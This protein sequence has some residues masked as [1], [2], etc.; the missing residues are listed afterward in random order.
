MFNCFLKYSLTIIPIIK[1]QFLINSVSG[2]P[3]LVLSPDF[4]KFQVIWQNSSYPMRQH[5]TEAVIFPGYHLMK[6]VKTEPLKEIY[7]RFTFQKQTN[8]LFRFS[9]TLTS[10]MLSSFCNFIQN[11]HNN[12][13][14]L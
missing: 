9:N 2:F 10:N 3:L 4:I 14:I 7:D 11:C 13:R 5:F 6:A 12:H 1:L 8:Q